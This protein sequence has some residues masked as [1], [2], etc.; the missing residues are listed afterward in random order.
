MAHRAFVTTPLSG[1][2]VTVISAR[3]G[4]LHQVVITTAGTTLDFYD[5]PSSASGRKVAPT[6][7]ATGVTTI[8]VAYNSGLTVIGAGSFTGSIITRE[9]NAG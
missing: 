8:D 1:S 2:G 6:V 5:H 4:T 7:T 9:R 3:P